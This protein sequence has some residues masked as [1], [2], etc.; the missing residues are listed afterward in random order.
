MRRPLCAWKP[1]G[2]GSSVSQEPPCVPVW[3]AAIAAIVSVLLKI[4]ELA[5]I[6]YLR[7]HWALPQNQE[8]KDHVISLW[9][10]TLLPCNPEILLWGQGT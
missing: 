7:D 1:L 3:N 9:F 5:S 4:G 2:L 8:A 10:L 6:S